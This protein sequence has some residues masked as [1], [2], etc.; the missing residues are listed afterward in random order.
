MKIKLAAIII[1]IAIAI[2]P[3]PVLANETSAA[4]GASAVAKFVRETKSDR[5]LQTK[6]PDDVDDSAARTT[7]F[8]SFTLPSLRV[9]KNAARLVLAV[10]V[11]VIAGV[12]IASL[13]DNLWSFS[14]SRELERLDDDSGGPGFSAARMEQAQADADELAKRGAY[15]EAMHVLLLRSVAELRRGLAAPIAA[16]LTSREILALVKL[17]PPGRDK[18][19]DIISRVEITYFGAREPEAGEYFACRD[20]F[21]TLTRILRGGA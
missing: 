17:P 18:L 20:S 7:D 8:P 19:A 11:C 21:D 4:D 16:S 1:F 6:M 15:A 12:V 9:S 5:T 2:A 13:K 10:A 3:P 14:R